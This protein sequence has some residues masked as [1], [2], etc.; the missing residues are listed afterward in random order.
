MGL[1]GRYC[2]ISD[3]MA[4]WTGGKGGDGEVIFPGMYL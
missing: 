1:F 2:N 4:I 3:K